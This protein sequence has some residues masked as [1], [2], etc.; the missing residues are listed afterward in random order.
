M[1]LLRRGIV[2]NAFSGAVNIASGEITIYPLADEAY[3]GGDRTFD[4]N[5]DGYST[6]RF[7]GALPYQTS[8]DGDPIG[9]PQAEDSA[10]RPLG[11]GLRARRMSNPGPGP[12][13]HVTPIRHMDPNW[14]DEVSHEQIAR[15]VG[16]IPAGE[17]TG[18]PRTPYNFVGFTL[19]LEYPAL[20]L[21]CTSRALNQSRFNAGGR[22][23]TTWANTIRAA[24]VTAA[25]PK[26]SSG[27]DLGIL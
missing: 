26:P 25:L 3:P 24:F 9:Y 27:D 23:S 15:R 8:P 4:P 22:M 7:P 17:L 5:G 13:L 21:V 6:S 16:G 18:G 20:R 2:G 12:G 19:W 1:R 11:G 10:A 14:Q